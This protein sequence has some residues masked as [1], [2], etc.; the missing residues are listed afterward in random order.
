MFKLIG[1]AAAT[2]TMFSFVPQVVKMYKTRHASD[3]S[4]VML[5]QMSLGVALWAVYGVS[6]RDPIIIFANVITLS[7]LLAALFL[8]FRFKNSPC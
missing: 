7:T 4:L 6:V 5:V 3:V 8:Y 1:L 2:L